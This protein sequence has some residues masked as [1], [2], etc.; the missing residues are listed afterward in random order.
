MKDKTSKKS[1][2]KDK[3][4]KREAKELNA[5]VGIMLQPPGMLMAGFDAD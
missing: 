1:E 5:E 2:K 4:K 3:K